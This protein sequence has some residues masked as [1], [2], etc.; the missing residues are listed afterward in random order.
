[1]ALSSPYAPSTMRNSGRRN[2]RRMRSSR[3]VRQASALS[4]S[5]ALT[6]DG[7]RLNTPE[8]TPLSIPTNSAT[9]PA[10]AEIVF[11][12]LNANRW[13]A[14]T[15]AP[16]RELKTGR[17]SPCGERLRAS[18]GSNQGS[19]ASFTCCSALGRSSACAPA[20]TRGLR[21]GL[22]WRDGCDPVR[23]TPVFYL[24]PRG[25]V[26]DSSMEAS[27]RMKL[28]LRDQDRSAHL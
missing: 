22:L 4:P 15:H 5:D 25:F 3:T 11:S 10:Q 23:T 9:E 18:A 27:R 28:Q 6:S 7:S 20:R 26:T 14:S 1:M 17:L 12:A 2:P 19:A 24:R 16:A 8:T 13:C 21:T